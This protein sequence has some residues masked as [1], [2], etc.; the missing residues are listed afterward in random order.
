MLDIRTPISL[1][2]LILGG[3]LAIYGL[4]SDPL[5]Y[6]VSLGHNL[7]L[8]WG[9]VMVVFGGSMG[10]WRRLAPQPAAKETVTR[11]IPAAT[12]EQTTPMT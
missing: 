12:E 4:T 11:V 3:L 6:R 9:L 5:I 7:N 8:E 10:A 2:F 1:M